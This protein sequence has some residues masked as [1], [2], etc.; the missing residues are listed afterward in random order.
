MDSP[1]ATGDTTTNS[2]SNQLYGTHLHKTPT[3]WTPAAAA[4]PAVNSAIYSGQKFIQ[5][6][7]SFAKNSSNHAI[8]LR[9]VQDSYVNVSQMLRI[10][11]LLNF[12]TNDQV[13]AY[14]KNE[15]L[16]NPQY[17]PHSDAPTLPLFNDFTDHELPLLRGLWIPYDKAISIA[18]KFD[19]YKL[20][21]QLFLVDV[22]DF[23]ELPRA[24]N[25]DSSR[26]SALKRTSI[27]GD[28]F[29]ESP[30]KRRKSSIAGQEGL[31][32]IVQKAA[33]S[34]PNVPY[35]LPPL[36]FQEKDRE[37]VSD[38]KL[39]YSE[40]FKPDGDESK[41]QSLMDVESHFRSV[42]DICNA[43][44]VDLCSTLDVSLDAL[45]KTA[46]HYAA[47]LA[48]KTLLAS[49]IQL[50]IGLPIRGNNKGESPLVSTIQVTNAM[51]KGEFSDMLDTCLWPNLWL[52]DNKHQSILH[53][54]VL[55]AAKNF[56]SSKFYFSKILEWVISSPS[57]QQNLSNLCSKLI[58]AQEN[59]SGNTALHIA[60]EQELKWFIFLLLELNADLNMA[61]NLGVK[62]I[63][64]DCVK[65]VSELR[66]SFKNNSYSAAATNNLLQELNATE[67]H[68]EFLLSLVCTS[69]EFLAMQSPYPE[70]GE[71]ESE[72]EL[73]EK[74][75]PRKSSPTS[76]VNSSS[77]LSNKIFNSI[78]ELLTSTNE[79][80]EKVIHAK[81]AEINALNKELRDTTIMTA[82]NR[83][84]ARKI[85]SQISQIDTMKLQMTNISDKLQMFKKEF[86]EGGE[87]GNLS[88]RDISD[89]PGML[90]FDAD[91]PFLIRPIY[92]KL[93]NNEEVQ[94]SEE[95]IESLPPAEVL[96]ARVKAYEE[97][98]SA[99]QKELNNLRDYGILTAKFKKVVS[100]CT[101]VDIKE[102]DELLDG[103]LEAVEAQQ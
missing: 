49:I 64:F 20:I 42:I 23:D 77:L 86:S 14:L 53:H 4:L 5:I 9:R 24:E 76:E 81:K 91:E 57:K 73:N 29:L 102:V 50:R 17:L 63:D 18:V 47:T 11:V 62:P 51:E 69:S 56:K 34:N 13:E 38:I 61:N 93:A 52:L 46:V 74:K 37:L 60:G 65:Q 55:L 45:G 103:L 84:I 21:K 94:A 68:D 83:F 87:D 22:H 99:L 85:T 75:P 40:I 89:S 82:N 39:R 101:G 92:E 25:L 30:I 90:K 32:A 28:A 8:V 78:Q 97:V 43:K 3:L 100:Y 98:N 41:F 10:L 36:T 48:D 88:G 2:I 54:L 70:V 12:F 95:L 58:N 72:D 16:S 96:S 33:K 26:P 27:D 31:R 15:I 19:I 35:T 1:Q 79:E 6:T 67:E 7:V 71:L 44:S 59:Q 66:K 80:Y